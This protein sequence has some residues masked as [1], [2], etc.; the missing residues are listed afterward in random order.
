MLHKLKEFGIHHSPVQ[1]VIKEEEKKQEDQGQDDEEQRLIE[2]ETIK[3]LGV[4]LVESDNKLSKG[5][6]FGAA[7]IPS[8][9]SIR[10][11]LG[12]PTGALFLQ[13]TKIKTLRQNV[14][15]HK[16]GSNSHYTS[17]AGQAK[18]GN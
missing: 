11:K 4:H 15:D 2:Q 8:Y 3:D 18:L 16:V 6:T 14:Y 9:K 12:S 5:E 13:S 1:V 7:N 10:D 17:I